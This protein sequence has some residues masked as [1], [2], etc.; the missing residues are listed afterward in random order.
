MRPEH[1]LS[2]QEARRIAVAA[3]GLD[4]LQPSVESAIRQM[5]I[6]QLDFV[7]VVT[8]SHHLVL[9]SRLGAYDRAALDSAVYSPTRQFTEHW[10]HE[11]SIVP[12]DLWPYLRYRREAHRIRPWGFEKQFS[13]KYL[14]RVLKEVTERGPL[15]SNQLPK[16]SNDPGRLKD[17]WYGTLQRVA[18]EALFGAGELSVVGRDPDFARVYN[19]SHRVIPAEHHGAEIPAEE[20]HRE[21]LRRAA[22]ALG[23]ATVAD[24]ADYFRMPVTVAKPRVQELAEAGELESVRV[25]GWKE[26]AYMHPKA[27]Q[28]PQTERAVLLSPFDPLIWFRKRTL[29]LFDFEYKLEIFTP[30]AKRRW[31]C[32]VLPFLIGDRLVARVDVKAERKNGVLAVLATYIEAGADRDAIREHLPRELNALAQWLGLDHAV[33]RLPLAN[34]H[35]CVRGTL[36][37]SPSTQGAGRA[38]S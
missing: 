24:L 35:A 19:L 25:E 26:S 4:C 10:A 6:L 9:F 5:A 2:L 23:V 21:V 15:R 29:K 34:H 18:A 1:Q 33:I 22:K 11:A 28:S 12:L 32:F 13:K 20:Q 14:N 17:T 38:R 7:N 30:E 37:S 31:G 3:Q 8:P 16:P 27:P 36:A